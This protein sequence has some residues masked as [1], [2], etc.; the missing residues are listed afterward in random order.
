MRTT[1]FNEKGKNPLK[2]KSFALAIRIVRLYQFL[3]KEKKEYTLSK[4]LLRA[5]TNPGAMTREAQFAQSG[6]DFVNKLEIAQKETS[7]TMYW[8][9][10]LK[11][12]D[13]ITEKQFT[14]IYKDTEEI[15]RLLVSIIKSRKR[16][17][18]VP[19]LTP[20]H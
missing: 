20:N 7:E 5:G 19:P 10:L 6:K 15:M 17:L 16:N 1:K 18:S 14:S 8:L 4:Q 9:E 12:T 11:E 2:D 3:K 13:Y